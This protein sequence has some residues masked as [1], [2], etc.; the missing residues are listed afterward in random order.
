M[1]VSLVSK[2][3]N[4]SVY[5]GCLFYFSLFTKAL[6]YT[7]DKSAVIMIYPPTSN[8]LLVLRIHSKRFKQVATGKY[9]DSLHHY[10]THTSLTIPYIWQLYWPVISRKLFLRVS[11]LIYYLLSPRKYGTD[12]GWSFLRPNKLHV[13]VFG[14]TSAEFFVEVC[15]ITC[16][17]YMD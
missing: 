7:S 16:I 6:V 10:G 17:I 9:H 2:H 5:N 15:I 1:N 12:F 4:D 14:L 11:R 3:F 8:I 13:H